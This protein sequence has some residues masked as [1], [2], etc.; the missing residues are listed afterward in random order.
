MRVQ[1]GITAKGMTEITSGLH[2]GQNIVVTGQ[3]M[4]DAESTLRGGFAAMS[5][6]DGTHAQKH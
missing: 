4:I 6:E 3:F 2:E 1:T 5:A